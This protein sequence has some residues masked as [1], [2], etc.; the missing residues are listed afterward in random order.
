MP[1]QLNLQGPSTVQG[2]IIFN[3]INDGYYWSGLGGNNNFTTAANWLSNITPIAGGRLYFGISSRIFPNNNLTT[4]TYF[5]AFEF[6]FGA[7]PFTITGNQLLV[8]NI[9]NNSNNLQTFT[10]NISSTVLT[11]V[12][13]NCA[14]SDIFTNSTL[15]GPGNFTKE[16]T[17]TLTVSG[18]FS[19][20]TFVVNNG[21]LVVSTRFNNGFVPTSNSI[22]VNNG[23]IL[24]LGASGKINDNTIITINNGG[25]YSTNGLLDT[26]GGVTGTGTLSAD[27]GALFQTFSLPTDITFDGKFSGSGFRFAL[28]NISSLN[29][30]NSPRTFTITNPTSDCT[31]TTPGWAIGGD[32][33][34]A[35]SLGDTTLKLGANNVI[36]SSYSIRIWGSS[37]A[38]GNGSYQNTLDL[39]GTDQTFA[40]LQF[41][42]TLSGGTMPAIVTNNGLQDSTLTLAPAS[43]I[44]YNGIIK[45]GPTNKISLIKD[46][47][48]GQSLS[49]TTPNT[50]TGS[51][52]ILNTG[53]LTVYTKSLSSNYLNKINYVQFTN[54][55]LTVNFGTAPLAGEIYIIL[56]GPTVN[57]YSSVVLQNAP[58]R[59]ASYNSPTSTLTIA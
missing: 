50:Y 29:T 12:T 52:Q 49:G 41:G 20:N 40:G 35:A 47:T 34:V 25:I 55:S 15:T 16:G 24:K 7:S 28:Q 22:T 4:N 10:T 32:A 58:G 54:T 39:N 14:T 21:T 53:A 27:S 38:S 5:S 9:I 8:S 19:A 59:T 36:P 56:P 17:G 1:S 26:I 31:S 46:G 18:A 57:T 23:G 44:T 37:A 13:I 3:S 43:L 42:Y 2:N 30:N 6:V 45:N 48:A 51:T 11:P 33:N